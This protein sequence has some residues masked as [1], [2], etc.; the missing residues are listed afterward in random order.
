MVSGKAATDKEEED[1][2]LI[3]C[4]A[5]DRKKKISH[6]WTRMNTD[7]TDGIRVEVGILGT[8]HASDRILA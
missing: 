3:G 5:T 1:S 6:R 8:S 2:P 4:K 7:K